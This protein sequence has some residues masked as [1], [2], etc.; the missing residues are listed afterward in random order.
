MARFA[1]YDKV[2]FGKICKIWPCK[3]WQDL[4]RS[5]KVILG[6]ILARYDKVRFARF[7]KIWQG[8]I[9]QDLARYDKVNLQDLARYD[10]V[11]LG[12]IRQDMTR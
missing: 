10:K 1:R 3:I 5:Y 4:A 11:I 9:W 8:K 7:G 6:K 12:K 2:I